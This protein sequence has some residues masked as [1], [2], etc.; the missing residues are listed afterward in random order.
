MRI[1]VSPGWNYDYPSGSNGNNFEKNDP[2]LIKMLD[3]CQTEDIDVIFGEWGHRGGNSID[4][5]WLE[6]AVKFYEY[7]IK[8]KGYSCIK[9]YNM[10]NEPNG[11][12]SSINGN[13]ALW[14]QL[15]KTLHEKL[16]EYNLADVAPIIGPD[17][18]I[19]DTYLVNWVNNTKNNI[20][21][22]VTAYDIHTY[23]TETIVRSGE[24]TNIIQAY[25]N[26]APQSAIMIMGELGFKYDAN[27]D[28]GRKN[29]QLINADK[30]ASDDSNMMI[31]EAFYGIDMAD[32]VIQNMLAGY[33]G[34][35]LWDLDDA[36]YNVSG[37]NL[38]RWGFWNILGAEA[39]ENTN[40][41]NIRP[42]FYTMSLLSKYFPKGTEIKSVTFP[43][44]RGLRAVAG[45][46]NGKYSIAIVNS[47]SS[48]Y[49]FNLIMDNGIE[50][51]AMKKF[52]YVADAEGAGFEGNLDASGFAAPESDNVTLDLSGSVEIN[53]PARSFILYSNF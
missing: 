43:N 14:E 5:T 38:K 42:W 48:D 22:I 16:V 37:K 24:Y 3:F 32:V 47:N 23:P 4:Q 34:I 7:L 35:I 53:L 44:K 8:T 28:L 20:G 2:L 17:I 9:Y 19:W 15:I 46:K 11:D 21:N 1:M 6:T 49:N 40:D 39:F 25:R 27:S 26:A 13:Y 41:E 51:K 36:M 31:Y 29:T 52:V 12:W 33:A 30:Y 18:A 45:I 10:V 50:L